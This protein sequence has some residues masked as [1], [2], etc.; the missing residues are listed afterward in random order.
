M[1]GLSKVRKLLN[2]G[3]GCLVVSDLSKVRKLLNIGISCLVQRLSIYHI[4]QAVPM[5]ATYN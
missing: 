3:I 5:K 4:V 1:E 2:I